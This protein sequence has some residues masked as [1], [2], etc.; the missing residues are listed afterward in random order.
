MADMFG[1][2]AKTEHDVTEPIRLVQTNQGDKMADELLTVLDALALSTDAMFVIN[3]RHR[4]VF[5]NKA[6]Q[7]LLGFAYDDVVGRSCA[8]ILAG[9]DDFGNRY[10]SDA[11]PIVS[12]ASR[13]DSVRQF[14]LRTKT[15]DQQPIALDVSVLK[16][17]LRAENQ[18]LLVHVVRPVD[19]AVAEL[20]PPRRTTDARLQN[21]T[22]RETEI[23]SLLTNGQTT[24]DIAK[25]LGIAP[26]TARNHMQNMFEKLEVHSKSEAVSFA[27]RAHAV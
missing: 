20:T 3:Q 12:I 2:W 9:S 5:W 8:T 18:V 1:Q 17:V 11:C 16:F 25:R 4:I 24:R 7:H 22:P 27:F 6:L 15:R 10:C 26:L 23:L 13:G 14:H 21:L 19:V